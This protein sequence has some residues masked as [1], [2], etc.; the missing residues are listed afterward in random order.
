MIH[1]LITP[2]WYPSSPSDIGGSFFREQALALSENGCR[3]GVIYPTLLPLRQ[4]RSIFTRNHGLIEENDCGIPTIR[5]H[6]MKCFPCLPHINNIFWVQRGLQIYKEYAAR[7]GTPSIVHAHS[8]LY[9][10]VLA[11]AIK[12]KFG[13]PYVITEHSSSFARN[14][15]R[16]SQKRAAMA[17]VFNASRLLAVSP[18]FCELLQNYFGTASGC[19][20]PLPNIVSDCFIPDQT[21]V[22][23]KSKKGFVFLCIAMLS[24][25]KAVDNLIAAFTQAFKDKPS[26]R[27]RIGG[28]GP[29][30]PL[31][32]KL[33]MQFGVGDQVTFLGLLSRKQVAA[34]LSNADSFVLPSRYETFG[35]VVTEALAM[36]KPVI[37]TRCGGP[38]F[39]IREQDGILVPTDDV[40]SLGAALRQMCRNIDQYNASDIREACIARYGAQAIIKRLKVIYGEVLENTSKGLQ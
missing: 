35:V 37:A 21:T 19:W 11:R 8:T 5:W 33:A 2:S 17:S 34:E 3:V 38:E 1:I 6:G 4:W 29:E 40:N 25:I 22:H 39:I 32:E 28:D 15:I 14:T 24:K 16:L 13:I 27:L 18:P 26:I 10:G 12:Y 9:G 20:E 30:L 7:H 31:L 36:G 23:N